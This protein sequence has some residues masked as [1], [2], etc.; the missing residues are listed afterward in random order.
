[1]L[2]VSTERFVD[3][4]CKLPNVSYAVESKYIKKM[5]VFIIDSYLNEWWG[6]RLIKLEA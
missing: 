1:M 2:L 5:L 6:H 4:C 3:H